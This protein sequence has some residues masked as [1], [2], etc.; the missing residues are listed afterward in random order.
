MPASDRDLQDL[1]ALV[2]GGTKGIGHAVAARLRESG[3]RVLVTA[4]SAPPGV[5]DTD[6]VPA[7]VA[8]PDGC[9]RVADAVSDR[10]GGAVHHGS[11][12]SRWLLV[13]MDDDA[14]TS[15]KSS[16]FLRRISAQLHRH[17][18]ANWA[19]PVFRHRGVC[20]VDGSDDMASTDGKTSQAPMSFGRRS[21]S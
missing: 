7:D 10:L 14:P 12:V 20:I 17:R 5:P 4:R 19:R 18:A 21:C 16:S 13:R 15:H 11:A 1:R 9:A 8:T 2:T 6:F 3:A